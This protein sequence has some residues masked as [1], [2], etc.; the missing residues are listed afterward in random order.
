M[1]EGVEAGENEQRHHGAE[2]HHIVKFRLQNIASVQSLIRR[3]IGGEVSF[4]GCVR[5]LQP[6]CE[7]LKKRMEECTFF[8]IVISSNK[9]TMTVAV[10]N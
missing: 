4:C 2:R 8:M 6:T 1:Y 3:S 10:N 9:S 5:V 7:V